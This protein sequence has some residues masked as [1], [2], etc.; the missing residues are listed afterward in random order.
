MLVTQFRLILN[1]KTSI[2]QMF[3]YK[4]YIWMTFYLSPCLLRYCCDTDSHPRKHNNSGVM[5]NLRWLVII[6]STS[7]ALVLKYNRPSTSTTYVSW[8]VVQ[9]S[10][11]QLDVERATLTLKQETTTSMTSQSKHRGPWTRR[12]PSATYN[13]SSFL[14]IFITFFPPYV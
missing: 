2:Q 8:Y 5:G 9:R 10:C 1:I 14:Y 12:L 6:S 11:S 7:T 3:K 4:T 13:F